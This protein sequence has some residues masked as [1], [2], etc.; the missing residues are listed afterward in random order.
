MDSIQFSNEIGYYFNAFSAL[1]CRVDS[2]FRRGGSKCS[3]SYLLIELIL[4]Y[5]SRVQQPLERQ[6]MPTDLPLPAVRPSVRCGILEATLHFLSPS[7][8]PFLFCSSPKKRVRWRRRSSRRYEKDSGF[9]DAKNGACLSPGRRKRL[10][11][12][13]AGHNCMTL[14]SACQIRDINL[15][16]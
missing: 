10:L 1:L 2:E 13:L 3:R 14:C 5:Q 15:E 8:G 11:L 16:T 12:A 6:N 7:L 9:G 4:D